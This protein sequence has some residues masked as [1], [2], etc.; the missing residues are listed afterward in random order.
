MIKDGFDPQAPLILWHCLAM[1]TEVAV[2]DEGTLVAGNHQSN[3]MLVL[4]HRFYFLVTENRFGFCSIYSS[5]DGLSVFKTNSH[6]SS[7]RISAL[8][9]G[10]F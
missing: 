6:L 1:R 8:V 5:E 7:E 10:S 2:E 9:R 4:S 3:A